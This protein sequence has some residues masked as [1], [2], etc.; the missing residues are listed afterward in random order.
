MGRPVGPLTKAQGRNFIH[1]FLEYSG[2]VWISPRIPNSLG[3]ST[4]D[5]FLNPDFVEVPRTLDWLSAAP[6]RG[7]VSPSDFD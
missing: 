7:T 4:P 3:T 1:S 2:I 6:A 5:G